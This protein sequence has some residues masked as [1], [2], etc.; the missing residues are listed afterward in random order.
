MIKICGRCF[1][2]NI[3]VKIAKKEVKV[4]EYFAY[5]YLCI[6]CLPLAREEMKEELK[7]KSNYKVS[8]SIKSGRIGIKKNN[9]SGKN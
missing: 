4:L 5:D 3:F 6:Y 1:N 9:Y 7:N 2:N 8:S